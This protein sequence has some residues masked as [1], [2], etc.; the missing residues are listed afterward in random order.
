MSELDLSGLRDGLLTE[1][2]YVESGDYIIDLAW[3]PDSCKLAAVTVEGSVL[4][5]DNLGDS[6]TFNVIGEHDSG[7]NSVSWCRDGAEFA[8]AG[9]D[10]LVRVWDGSSGEP[11]AELVAGDD[12]VS[13]AVFNPRRN[14]L[15]TAAGKHLKLWNA[16]RELI[17]ESAD[18]SS[19]IADVGWNPDGS[20]MAVAAYNGVTLHVPGKQKQPRTYK[21]KGSSLLLAWSPDARYIATGEQDST[22]HFWHVKSGDDAR[23]SGFRTKVLELSWDSTGQWLAT[24]GGSTICLWDCSGKGP[25]G[26]EPRMYDAHNNKLTQLAFQ[27]D[28]T[29]LASTDAD[30]LLVL[31]DPVKHNKMISGASLSSPACC[32]RW[33]QGGGLAVG[34]TDGR[35]VVFRVQL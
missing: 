22:V 33:C 26:R 29:I 21:W 34:Q 24:G 35:V 3:S 4:L 23:M 25:A 12:W 17:Y 5:I 14:L 6:A 15:A 19:T 31:W 30:S 8:T 18:H 2:W 28:G 13:K 20:G 16:Q 1:A 10:G 32:V 7:A 9:Q 27:P 11:L